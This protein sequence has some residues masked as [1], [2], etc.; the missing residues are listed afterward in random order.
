MLSVATKPELRQIKWK[1]RQ[2]INGNPS[3]Q[4]N[5]VSLIQQKEGWKKSGL[6]SIELHQRQAGNGSASR[7]EI[8]QDKIQ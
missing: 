8:A 2:G 7:E 6:G 1:K 4:R 3:Y 5:L